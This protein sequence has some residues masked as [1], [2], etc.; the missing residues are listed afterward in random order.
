[1]DRDATLGARWRGYRPSKSQWFWSCVAC[2]AGTMLVGFTWG[3]WVT[4]GTAKS[5][6][7]DAANNAKAQ[8][9]ADYC[10]DR[11]DKA[12]DAAGQLVSLRKT[13]TWEQSDFIVKGGWATPPGSKEAVDGAADLCAKQLL[14][15]KAPAANATPVATA[16]SGG[17]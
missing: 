1:M 12:A 8:L 6:T 13:G 15:A 4:A 7:A 14:A 2:V 5:M 9:A 3:G 10:V 11:F 17:G 16:K